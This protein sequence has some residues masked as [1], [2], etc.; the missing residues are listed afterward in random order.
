MSTLI[1]VA[2]RHGSTTGI[3]EVL[4]QELRE[5]GQTVDL[6]IVA[7]NPSI[8]NYEAVI[9]GS[10]VYMGRWLPQAR[11]FIEQH[12]ERLRKR[13]V[14][15]FSS[16]PT[17]PSEPRAKDEPAQIDQLITAAGAR[18]HRT[19]A[20]KLDRSKLG[21]G[22]RFIIWNVNRLKAGGVP[23]GDFRDWAAIRTW[24]N[25]IAG[26]LVASSGASV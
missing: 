22:E 1:V 26:A 13:P 8:E 21:L 17:D 5:A 12:Q 7:D 20:G 4:A 2:S 3:A 14:W 10:A 25:E 11:R 19:F 6:R 24:A 9:V 16:G 18:G 15:L 23:D